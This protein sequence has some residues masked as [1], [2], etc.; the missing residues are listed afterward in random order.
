[1]T[2]LSLWLPILLSAVAVFVVSSII[3]MV[4]GYHANN[5]KKIPDE[6]TFRAAVGPLNVPPGEYMYPFCS[7]PKDMESEEIQ[8]K[9][10]QGPVG[11]MTVMPNEPFAMGKNLLAWFIYS[12][13]VGIFAA[14]IA[15]RSLTP[16]AEYLSV[17]RMVG[18]AAFGGYGLALIQN[19]VWYS[20]SWTVTFKFLFDGLIYAAVT[21]G[22]F[23]WLWS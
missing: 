7:G 5:F 11:M 4:L 9:L 14:Y 13:I 18:A 19:S 12:L 3:H 22:V 15:S 17:M 2:I 16:D 20:R 8:N 6:E 23:G 10:K 21:G 1:M